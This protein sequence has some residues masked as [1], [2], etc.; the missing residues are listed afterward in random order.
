MGKMVFF[1]VGMLIVG[2]IMGY[3]INSQV[4]IDAAYN[5]CAQEC[6]EIIKNL[7][8]LL[9]N[10]IEVRNYAVKTMMANLSPLNKT[11]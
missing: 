5:E 2:F 8:P 10:Q 7:S 1:M 6:N 9:S 4:R 11:R 3:A